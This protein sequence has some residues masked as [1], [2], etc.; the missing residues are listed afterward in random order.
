MHDLIIL[1]IAD[2]SELGEVQCFSL[3][4]TL[5]CLPSI[6][7]FTAFLVSLR[8]IEWTNK[9]GFEKIRSLKEDGG[10]D[11]IYSASVLIA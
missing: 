9:R 10:N 4:F 11:N 2:E 8:L 3:T 7:F 6:S 1:F 5:P